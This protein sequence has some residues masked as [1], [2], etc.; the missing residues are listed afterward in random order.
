[1][2]LNPWDSIRKMQEDDELGKTIGLIDFAHQATH[3]LD[4]CSLKTA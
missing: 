3:L 1:M 4:V 2:C